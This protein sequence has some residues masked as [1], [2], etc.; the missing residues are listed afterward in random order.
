[1]GDISRAS[2]ISDVALAIGNRTDL[3]T[4]IA[5]A[6]N[7]AYK[8]ITTRNQFFGKAFPGFRYAFPELDGAYETTTVDG[9]AYV[10]KPDSCLL[11][12]SVH[13]DENDRK[14]TY[15]T[16]R[17]YWE[18]A[19]RADT[20]SEGQPSTWTPYGHYL[21]LYPTPDGAY[22]ITEYYRMKVE[23]LTDSTDVTLIGEEWDEPIARLAMV[24]MMERLK[25]FEEAAQHKGEF[26]EMVAG[27][28]SIYDEQ[29]RDAKQFFKPDSTYIDFKY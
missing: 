22:D 4:Q 2:F 1:M 17:L 8:D 18:K 14:L 25:M 7:A 9:T 13:D 11:V 12:Y 24:Y 29:V 21:Y 6:V 23:E 27:R 28:L 5:A 20:A 15:L 10:S 16:P 26:T 19:G 3:D